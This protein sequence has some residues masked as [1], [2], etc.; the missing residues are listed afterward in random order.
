ML[1]FFL[2]SIKTFQM[3][4]SPRELNL[5]CLFNRKLNHFSI[6]ILIIIKVFLYISYLLKGIKN[7]YVVV[8][9]VVKSSVTSSKVLKPLLWYLIISFKSKPPCPVLPVSPAKEFFR[10]SF[11]RE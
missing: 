10:I 11:S 3:T 2:K 8:N 5:H 4:D 7:E 9:S 1:K 6:L